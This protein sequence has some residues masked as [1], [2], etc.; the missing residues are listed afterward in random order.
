MFVKSP[1]NALPLD[2]VSGVAGR[3]AP[4]P[5]FK[6]FAM[7]A[8]FGSCVDGLDATEHRSREDGPDFKEMEIRVAM[9]E[10]CNRK[11]A[12]RGAGAKSS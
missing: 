5:I 3:A 9:A 8:R 6:C 2:V 12:I 7:D 11:T 1:F 4:E 10:R